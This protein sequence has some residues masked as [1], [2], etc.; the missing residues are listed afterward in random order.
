MVEEQIHYNFTNN[1]VIESKNGVLADKSYHIIAF[2][3]WSLQNVTKS[4]LIAYGFLLIIK[5]CFNYN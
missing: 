5:Q 4:S 1:T 2:V 3:F